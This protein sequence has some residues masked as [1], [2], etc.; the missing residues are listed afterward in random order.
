MSAIKRLGVGA[1]VALGGAL[2]MMFPILLAFFGS[3][4]SGHSMFDEGYG[5]GAALWFL[6]VTIPL[7]AI[8]IVLGLVISLLGKLRKRSR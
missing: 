4:G 8:I 5:N 2:L 6:I 3:I 7:G 1:R